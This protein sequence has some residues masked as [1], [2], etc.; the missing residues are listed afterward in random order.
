M[1]TEDEKFEGGCTG[2]NSIPQEKDSLWMRLA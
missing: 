2:R 1:P